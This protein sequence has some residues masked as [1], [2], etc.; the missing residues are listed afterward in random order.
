MVILSKYYGKYN[1]ADFVD[2]S[3]ED[4]EKL[5]VNSERIDF[6]TKYINPSTGDNILK[7]FDID[8]FQPRVFNP[9][10]ALVEEGKKLFERN[11]WKLF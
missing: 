10:P 6:L 5:K 1:E 7:P 11:S 3:E 2:L 9:D 4:F 8:N